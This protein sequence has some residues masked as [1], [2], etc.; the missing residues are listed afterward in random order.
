LNLELPG[1]RRENGNS[2]VFVKVAKQLAVQKPRS[3]TSSYLNPAANQLMRF[4]GGIEEKRIHTTFK[5]SN[6]EVLNEET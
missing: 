5:L 1:H 2:A 4:R 6:F 3:F